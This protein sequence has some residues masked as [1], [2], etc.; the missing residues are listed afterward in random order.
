MVWNFGSKFPKF[1]PPPTRSKSPR[2]FWLLPNI[3]KFGQNMLKNK[4]NR[5]KNSENSVL[6]VTSGKNT[7]FEI[8]NPD[9]NIFKSKMQVFNSG[10]FLRS[11]LKAYIGL[12][13]RFIIYGQPCFESFLSLIFFFFFFMKRRWHGRCVQ[14]IFVFSIRKKEKKELRREK[15]IK[16]SM[17]SST[18]RVT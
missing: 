10:G 15:K 13:L 2:N 16:N 5:P 18:W 14:G 8:A 1:R 17:S 7:S 9:Y 3:F 6:S 12:K 4:K 11:Q